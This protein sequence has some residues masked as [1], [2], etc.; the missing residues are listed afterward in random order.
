L[1]KRCEELN[2]IVEAFGLWNQYGAQLAVPTG[3]AAPSP[4]APPG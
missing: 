1:P 4:P 3:D 2:C